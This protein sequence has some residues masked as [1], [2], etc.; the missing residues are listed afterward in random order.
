MADRSCNDR[1]RYFPTVA[2]AWADGG[3]ANSIDSSL[4]SGAKD[5]LLILLE[6]VK[7]TDHVKGSKVLL[8]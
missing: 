4:S 1:S 6:I 7:R 8:A 3:D 2:R 5:K